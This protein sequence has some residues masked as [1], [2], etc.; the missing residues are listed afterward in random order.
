MIDPA[1]VSPG[2]IMPPY[3]H[4]AEER[5]DLDDTPAKLRAMRAVGVPYDAAAIEGAA[6]DARR[7]AAAIAAQ[8]RTK[9]GVEVKPETRLIAL[10]A[11]LQRLGAPPAPPPSPA[12]IGGR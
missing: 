9:A 1:E 4:L 8:I 2:S 7:Q 12:P 3:P 11:Y 6:A 5:L 10:I